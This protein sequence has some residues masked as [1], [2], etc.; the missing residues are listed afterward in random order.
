VHTNLQH[1]FHLV[2]CHRDYILKHVDEYDLFLYQEDDLLIPFG[3]IVDCWEKLNMWE[4][5]H[6][7]SSH[8]RYTPSF[9]RVEWN[10]GEYTVVDTQQQV[11]KSSDII[12]LS[13]VYGVKRR[14]ISPDYPYSACWILDQK[15]VKGAINDLFNSRSVFREHAASLPLGPPPHHA[16]SFDD[17]TS[18]GFLNRKPLLEIDCNNKIV[19]TSIIYHL[20]NKYIKEFTVPLRESISVE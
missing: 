13:D 20:P 9:R 14:Y 5:S 2:W 19:A 11:V 17:N 12:E 8:P 1:G 3:N 18:L 6:P 15:S 16:Y 4:S 10:G 7:Q